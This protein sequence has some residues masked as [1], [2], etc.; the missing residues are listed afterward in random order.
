MTVESLTTS[1][2]DP[3]HGE[4]AVGFLSR[5]ADEIARVQVVIRGVGLL[6]PL[7][8]TAGQTWDAL[9]AGRYI[10]DHARAAGEFDSSSPRVIQMARRVAD[11]ALADAGWAR[12]DDFAVVVG[13][14]KG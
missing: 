8:E 1:E 5:A 9:L 6:T 7:G 12:G 11:Q 4:R 3:A 13:T 10:T 2:T 14:S